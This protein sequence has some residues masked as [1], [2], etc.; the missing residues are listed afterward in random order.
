[1]HTALR[2]L[3]ASAL[4]SATRGVFAVDSFIGD[5]AVTDATTSNV[6]LLLGVLGLLHSGLPLMSRRASLPSVHC[7][8]RTTSAPLA[9]P[10]CSRV[11]RSLRLTLFG[12]GRLTKLSLFE[13]D[14]LAAVLVVAVIAGGRLFSEWSCAQSRKGA[15]VRPAAV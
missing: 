3:Q 9:S 14:A 2:L 1:M 4:V 12:L 6:R 13:G 11:G 7:R 5:D 8:H 10:R 15:L